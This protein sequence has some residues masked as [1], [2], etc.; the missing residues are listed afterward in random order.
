[1][2][3]QV[4][5]PPGIPALLATQ[6][7]AETA[8][9]EELELTA[10]STPTCATMHSYVHPNTHPHATP[11]LAYWS[12]RVHLNSPAP[13]PRPAG[14]PIPLPRSCITR[15][16]SKSIHLPPPL[17]PACSL[18]RPEHGFHLHCLL[19]PLLVSPAGRAAAGHYICA[20]PAPAP[21]THSRPA[22]RLAAQWA[23][24]SPDS[25]QQW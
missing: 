18:A 24:S 12:P 1:M 4:D 10:S 14:M 2:H 7:C 8:E 6:T 17:S 15:T 21:A 20:A 16:P 5:A 19:A 13:Y 25:L 22:A 11:H 9:G 3:G 23:G